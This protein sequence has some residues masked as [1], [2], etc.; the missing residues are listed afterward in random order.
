M[1]PLNL[2]HAHLASQ[3]KSAVHGV[4]LRS[5]EVEIGK[6]RVLGNDGALLRP[7]GDSFRVFR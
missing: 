3:L 4:L 7:V 6:P 1:D 5:R 2:T